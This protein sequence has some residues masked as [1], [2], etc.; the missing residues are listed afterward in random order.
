M[1]RRRGRSGDKILPTVPDNTDTIPSTSGK[2][3]KAGQGGQGKKKKDDVS[4]IEVARPSL[5]A[6]GGKKSG[7]GTRRKSVTQED[8][9]VMVNTVETSSSSGDESDIMWV[10]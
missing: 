9:E 7:G 6:K 4:F 8:L 10:S 1:Q 2:R 3:G 5:K